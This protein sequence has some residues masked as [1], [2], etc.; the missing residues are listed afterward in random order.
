MKVAF[1]TFMSNYDIVW[2][3]VKNDLPPLVKLLKEVV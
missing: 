1:A 2:D 3:T